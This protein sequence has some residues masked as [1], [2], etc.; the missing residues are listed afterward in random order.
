MYETKTQAD[1]L[2]CFDFL[3]MKRTMSDHMRDIDVRREHS[4]LAASRQ[5]DRETCS[6]CAKF[7]HFN[8]RVRYLHDVSV[9]DIRQ[10]EY[11]YLTE[12]NWFGD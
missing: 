12:I 7:G 1:V 11:K 8:Q 5:T 9:L 10:L 6:V 4:D 3:C 2:G